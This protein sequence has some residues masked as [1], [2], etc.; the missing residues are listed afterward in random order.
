MIAAV[1]KESFPG[2]KRVALI[3]RNVTALSQAGLDVMV[4]SGAGEASL[5]ADSEY[6]KAGA[7]IETDRGALLS[8]T[9]L[10]L[11][12]RG[13]GAFAGFPSEELD[14]LKKGTILI[15]FLEP[16]AE[17]ETMQSL[18]SRG[19]TAF[20]MEL[21][22]R[23]TRAQTMDALSSMASI[24]GYEAVL[25]GAEHSPK[26]FP[27]QIT[28]AGTI[29][30][31]KVFVLGA[32]VAGLQAI[33]TARRLGA[34]VEAYDIRPVVKEEAESL[35]ARFVELKIEAEAEGQGGYAAAQS[36]EFHRRQRELLAER[37]ASA[38]VIITTAAVPG[39]RAPILITTDMTEHLRPGAVVIDLAAEKGGNCELTRAGETVEYQGV[40]IVGP[41]N[42]P[43]RAA[44]HASQM[45]SKN[46]ATFVDLL[47]KG[48]DLTLDLEDEIIKG[49][50]VT[51][52]GRV[53]HS[54]VLKASGQGD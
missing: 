5:H 16:L 28:A 44:Y 46:I 15:G 17:P 7:R 42:L 47:V 32:G 25:L 10:L 14:R 45:Y 40:T 12:V 6:E 20:A 3:P 33:A 27:M 37:L 51:H 9:D 2:E 39:K 54:A 41:V 38:D 24:A 4:E 22:P 31:A 11:T 43:S 26:M 34:L 13:P 8:E 52:Q 48:G 23:I 1:I 49:T 36:E 35:G 21:V 19:V 29:T 18:A 50:L 30:P 53:V